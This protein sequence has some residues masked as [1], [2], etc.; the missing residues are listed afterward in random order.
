MTDAIAA[1][2]DVL[3]FWRTAG[4]AKWFAKDAAFDAAIRTQFLATYAAAA[5]GN[6]ASWEQT[7]ES[8]LAL[9]VVL[10]Q[11]PRNMFRDHSRAFAADS[12]AL[13]VAERAIGRGLD[14]L[15][16][17]DLRIFLY[18]PLEHCEQIGVQRRSVELISTLQSD[19]YSRYALVHH[20]IVARY[21]RFPH[22]NAILGREATPD[23]LLY[24][25]GDGFKG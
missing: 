16:G 1:P 25:A 2:H 12:L 3:N 21:G 20:D 13:A 19:D 15:I 10:D 6:L 8:T 22:R 18:L 5:A 4:P 23:E 17:P 9:I 11:F 7:A 14:R 24:L